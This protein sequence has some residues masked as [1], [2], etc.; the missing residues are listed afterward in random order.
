[1][2]DGDISIGSDTVDINTGSSLLD[3]NIDLFTSFGSSLLGGNIEV[4]RPASAL[5]GDVNSTGASPRLGGKASTG[6]IGS[7]TFGEVT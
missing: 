4:A 5:D 2:V 3:G 6:A 1:V 7:L